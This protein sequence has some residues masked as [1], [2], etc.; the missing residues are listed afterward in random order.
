MEPCADWLDGVRGPRLKIDNFVLSY[1]HYG[2]FAFK[3]TQKVGEDELHRYASRASRVHDLY[4]NFPFII[5]LATWGKS[6]LFDLR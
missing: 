5:L 1:L 2:L 4:E 3:G 6:W